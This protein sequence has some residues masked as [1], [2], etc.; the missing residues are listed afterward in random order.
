MKNIIIIILSLAMLGCT[1]RSKEKNVQKEQAEPSSLNTSWSLE[2]LWKSD[3]LMKTCE[4]VRYDAER[5]L[6]FVS[7][8][9]GAPWDKD[10]QGFIALLNLDGSL[11]S[12]K[13]ITGLDAPKGMGIL[14][15]KLYVADLN[16][17]VVI[18]IEKAEIL[19]KIPVPDAAQLNDIAIDA[20]GKIYFTDS[21][22]GWIWTMENGK[23]E[24]WIEGEFERPNGLFIEE[25][26]VLLVSSGSQDFTV[27]SLVDGTRE[28]VTKEIGHGDGV[29]FIGEE[30]HYLVT[31][32]SGEIFIILPDFSKISL[33]K[34]SDQG[35]NT[36]DI[37]FNMAEQIVYVPTFFDNR[38]VAYKLVKS[39]N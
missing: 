2:E 34:T 20:N 15:G 39:A 7:C 10:G 36:A 22:K 6:L 33:L 28:I 1:G 9:N 30:G 29:E 13:W 17:I 23:P 24:K 37:G 4:S 38:V 31:S 25:D 27:I 21:G 26:R 32:W 35:V 18:D 19:K 12:E 5:E 14:E 11:K 16:Q 3:T 8:I